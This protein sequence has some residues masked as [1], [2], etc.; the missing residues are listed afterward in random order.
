MFK[1]PLTLR[2]FSHTEETRAKKDQGLPYSIEDCKE[3]DVDFY[4]I[5]AVTPY[6]EAGIEY[7][8]IWSITDY[9]ICVHNLAKVRELIKLHVQTGGL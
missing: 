9:V 4:F 6:V 2:C 3:I 1:S 7:S 5:A 8:E